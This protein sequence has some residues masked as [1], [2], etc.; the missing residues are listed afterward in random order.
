MDQ[1]DST[2]AN[3]PCNSRSSASK[4][5][6]VAFLRAS[7]WLAA[8]SDFDGDLYTGVRFV[9]D[10]SANVSA[11]VASE[12]SSDERLSEVETGGDP[13]GRMLLLR[14]CLKRGETKFG[15]AGLRL[16]GEGCVNVGALGSL[17]SGV[18]SADDPC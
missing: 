14:F 5:A 15:G 13:V 7:S 3:V 2:E 11:A 8:A 10:V 1:R 6:T 18:E 16:D 17:S 9:G 4:P 12:R